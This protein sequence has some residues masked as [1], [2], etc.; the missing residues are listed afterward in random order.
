LQTLNDA[1]VFY[2]IQS[3]EAKGFGVVFHD[4]LSLLNF[5]LD[6]DEDKLEIIAMEL[7]ILDNRDRYYPQLRRLKMEFPELYAI[8]GDFFNEA[9][10]ARDPEKLLYQREKQFNK[11]KR[12]TSPADDAPEYVAEQPVR[13]AEPKV[14]RND[15]CPCGSGKKYKRCCGA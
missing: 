9:L 12:K 14:G 2:D 5:G 13:R 15:P 3:L 8:H 4:L 6:E 7:E 11:L 10:R 1:K